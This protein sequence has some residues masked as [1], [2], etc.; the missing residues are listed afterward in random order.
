MAYGKRIGSRSVMNEEQ[1]EMKAAI[2][3]MNGGMSA[4]LFL[5]MI[6]LETASIRPN[7]RK[8]QGRS[9]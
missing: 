8:L 6:D 3:G 2:G 1:P 4:I 5:L 7:S 9:F